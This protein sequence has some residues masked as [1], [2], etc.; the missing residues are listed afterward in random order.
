MGGWRY[1]RLKTL[2]PRAPHEFRWRTH[3]RKCP[4]EGQQEE[5]DAVE[6]APSIGAAA[7]ATEVYECWSMWGSDS[8]RPATCCSRFT[9][10][11]LVGT[12]GSHC[13][14]HHRG[15]AALRGYRMIV[16]I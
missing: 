9:E 7:M 3:Y 12:K 11:C 16:E 5:D 14:S 6:D 2:R 15:N 13:T 1:L 8:C 4:K 10:R